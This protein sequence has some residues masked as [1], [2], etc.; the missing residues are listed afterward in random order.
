MISS[1]YI[2]GKIGG[3]WLIVASFSSSAATAGA[4]FLRK[5]VQTGVERT[6]P[7]TFSVANGGGVTVTVIAASKAGKNILEPPTELYYSDCATSWKA[8]L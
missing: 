3:L 4:M 1:L 6:L 8:L 7:M 5:A 2:D